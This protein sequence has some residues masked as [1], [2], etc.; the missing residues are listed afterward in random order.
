MKKKNLVIAL[1]AAAAAAALAGC[2]SQQAETTAAETTAAETT[3][4]ETEETAA[5]E[6]E[7]TSE[8]AADSGETTA[9]EADGAESETLE[10]VANM[11]PDGDLAKVI[12]AGK[13]VLG[14]SPDFAPWEFQDVSSGTT[15][16][17][18]SD[19]ELAKYIAQRLGV[20]LE[21]R[22]ME[23]GAILQG[24]A[25]DTIDIGI[26]GFA[27][28]EERAEA[29]NLSDPYN[30]DSA[31]GQ[32]ILVLKDQTADYN[33]ADAFAG[34]RI[35]AQN[36]SLQM[37]LV[38]A[39]LPSDVSIQPVTTVS[40]GVLMLINGRVDAVA[41]SGDNG[42]SLSDSYPEV[43]MADF[44]FDYENDGNVVAIKKGNDELTAAVNEIMADVNENGLY[45]QW[46]AEAT[47]L[48]QSLGI[49]TN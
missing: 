29:A 15:E 49:E 48:A 44:K 46:K 9:A 21:I 32:G 31:A 26:S 3:A 43:G 23:F 42:L 5:E 12:N 38:Q 1:A 16:Y 19:I 13:I 6:T 35:A 14:T 39:Q 11:S 25:S 4:E 7:E 36:A 47:E 37:Q 18:G 28:T 2:S 41:V 45:E 27:Y 10:A 17:V 22:P 8:E 40:E 20:E 24:L 34:K 33:S 30:Q